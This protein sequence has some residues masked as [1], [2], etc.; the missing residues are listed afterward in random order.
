[1]QLNCYFRSW[2][3]TRGLTRK[4]IRV[5]K[6]TAIFLFVATMHVAAKSTGQTVTLKVKDVLITEVFSSIQKQ[7]G[8]NILVDASILD[9]ASRVSLD[10]KEMPVEKVMEMCLKDQP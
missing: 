10:V 2:S 9:D 8:Y 4:V 6:I 7:T 3:C 1:M 5:M